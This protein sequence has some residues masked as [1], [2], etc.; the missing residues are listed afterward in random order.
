MERQS[1]IHEIDKVDCRN[2]PATG[3]SAKVQH[4]SLREHFA[5]SCKSNYVTPGLLCDER[6]LQSGN[7]HDGV[8]SWTLF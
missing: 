3:L 4:Y 6:N 1:K 8:I 2:G 7:P 5:E